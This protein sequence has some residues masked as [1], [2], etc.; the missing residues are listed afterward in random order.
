MAE[1]QAELESRAREID[2]LTS[3]LIDAKVAAA[4]HGCEMIE[5]MH[6]VQQLT[7]KL[8]E[9]ETPELAAPPQEAGPRGTDSTERETMVTPRQSSTL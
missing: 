6:E 7:S 9:A 4:Q 5:R 2:E 8:E 1:L 3:M